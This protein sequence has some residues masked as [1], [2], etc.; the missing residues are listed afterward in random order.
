MSSTTGSILDRG[1]REIGIGY[2]RG[3]WSPLDV[4]EA[5]LAR[6]D[7]TEPRVH[8]WVMVDAD[9]ARAAAECAG[10][11]MKTGQ[12]RGILHGIPLGIKDIFDVAGMPTRCGSLAREHAL[13]ASQD[14]ASIAT[15]RARGA[16]LMGKTVTQEFAAGV[17]SQPARNPWDPSRIPGGS[18]GGSAVAVALGAVPGAMGSDTGGSIRIPAAACGVVGF[19]PAFGQ[20]DLQ[21]VFPLSWSL[22]TAGPLARTVDDAWLIWGT[23]QGAASGN[24]AQEPLAAEDLSGVRIGVPHGFFFNNLQPDVLAV[25]ESAIETLRQLGA[26]VIDAPWEVAA[27]A[28]AAAF[29]IN[30]VETSA[31]HE[32]FARAHPEEFALLGPDL[33]LRIAAG[34]AVPANLYLDA[35]RIRGAVRDSMAALFAEHRLDALVAP[36]LPT[37][38]VPADDLTITG[39][40]LDESLGAGWTRLT[41]PFNATGQPVLSVPIGFDSGALPVGVQLAGAP[42]REAGLFQIGA[43]LERALALPAMPPTLD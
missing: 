1:I 27:L 3:D 12:D 38:A 7:A 41:M 4:V 40:G 32:R 18:S 2:R 37:T 17:V 14:A 10:R 6:I 30:R 42:G 36:G 5:S 15:L 31:V 25:T 39:T 33:R 29:I 24:R 13:P 26:A 21:G 16:V 34:S 23:I 19:K 35:V 20:I 22:D 28:R 9:G 43:V 8:A 11:E